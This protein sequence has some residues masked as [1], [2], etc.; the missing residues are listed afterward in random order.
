[1]NGEYWIYDW[2]RS[3]Q[4]RF[5]NRWQHGN[6]VLSHLDD[7]NIV[8][9]SMQLNMYKYIL[10]KH[11]DVKIAG[12]C[13]GCCHPDIDDYDR[14]QVDIMTN[15]IELILENREMDLYPGKK[16]RYWIDV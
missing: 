14:V 10:E 16:K 13:L 8:H 15:E 7:C 9:Y 2:K 3:K 11:Y 6:G 4:F 1:M 12:M 5:D